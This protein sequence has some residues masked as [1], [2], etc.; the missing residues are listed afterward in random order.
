[1]ARSMIGLRRPGATRSCASKGVTRIPEMPV[2]ALRSLG[3]IVICE[4]PRS[5]DFWLG[6]TLGALQEIEVATLV[7]LPGVLCKQPVIATRVITR[8]RLISLDA[9]RDLRIAQVNVDRAPGYVDA[10]AI[11]GAHRR[12]WPADLCFR[13]DV[14][15]ASPVARSAHPRVG[16]PQH[17]AHALAQQRFRNWQ[18]APFR[19]TGTTDWACIAQDHDMIWGNRK[20]EIVY[21]FL[22]LVVTVEHERRP[23]ML[24]Q[25]RL[26][27]RRL[28]HTSVGSEI[29]V[30]DRGAAGG[31][32]RIIE[33]ADDVVVIHL[34]I[35]NCV[36]HPPGNRARI[37]MQH[38]L[39]PRQQRPRS[40]GNVELLHQPLA[41]WTQIDDHRHATRDLVEILQADR[42]PG[43]PCDG[44]EMDHGIGGARKRAVHYK[45]VLDGLAGEN[46]TW[47]EIL[48]DHLDDA[49]A[50]G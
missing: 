27:G 28:H 46:V 3:S 48:P 1:M 20:V 16:N 29:A 8:Q 9:L 17:V 41:G 30:K 32:D 31:G 25:A 15:D 21:R 19:H 12:E 14:Q 40:T 6:N 24:K 35:A 5:V 50:A 26:R 39:E 34:R 44:H 4:P 23:G 22:H 38:R 36:P 11:A 42:H 49:P 43:P 45:R 33:W 37:E 2:K 18:H 7:R 13:R 10:D 47:P